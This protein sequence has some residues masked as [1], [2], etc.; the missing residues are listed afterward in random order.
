MARWVQPKGVGMELRV[1][2]LGEVEPRSERKSRL[3]T[4]AAVVIAAGATAWGLAS[5]GPASAASGASERAA[6]CQGVHLP[7]APLLVR[8][9]SD[10]VLGT[11][12]VEQVGPLNDDVS[13]QLI[14]PPLT[15]RASS[16]DRCANEGVAATKLRRRQATAAVGCL[17]NEIRRANGLHVLAV[18]S[19]LHR[20]AKAHNRRMLDNSCFSHQC[21]GEPDLVHRVTTAGYLPCDCTWTVGENLAWGVRWRS[22]PSAIVDAWMHS[23]PHR[24]MILRNGIQDVGVGV[25][26]GR[27]GSSRAKG[28]TYT[29]DFGVKR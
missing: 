16:A 26:A 15:L 18:R 21:T 4:R 12:I 9:F 10:P 24:E 11:V 28:A 5:A 23:P 20:A 3:S 22:S 2:G 29:A 8:G 13:C 1:G 7:S 17:L 25:I 6:A 14:D 19:E 27:P